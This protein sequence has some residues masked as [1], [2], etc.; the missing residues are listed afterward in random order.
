VYGGLEWECH[1]PSALPHHEPNARRCLICNTVR[2]PK[3]GPRVVDPD[4]RV[5]V[6][7][8]CDDND[9]GEGRCKLVPRIRAALDASPRC[10][11]HILDCDYVCDLPVGH[12]GDHETHHGTIKWERDEPAAER[13][14]WN[15]PEQESWWCNCM[16]WPLPA[17]TV[18]CAA[19]GLLR[20]PL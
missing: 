14:R 20:P 8:I 7:A 3:E 6:R 19:C 12:D 11:N 4:L 1:C 18:R 10:G 15:S 13:G 16:R 9:C 17:S 2:P 5:T